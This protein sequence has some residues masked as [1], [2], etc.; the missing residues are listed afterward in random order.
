MR[1][2]SFTSTTAAP[3]NQ[4]RRCHNLGTLS[5]I[6]WMRRSSQRH[7]CISSAC[8]ASPCTHH[9]TISVNDE[10]EDSLVDPW[11]HSTTGVTADV[12][13]PADIFA[14]PKSTYSPSHAVS[15]STPLN[16]PSRHPRFV[17]TPGGSPSARHQSFPSA[18]QPA[19]F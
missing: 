2:H 1:I 16:D 6:R 18:S 15:S 7:T 3:Y 4:L 14:L 9:Y 8:N 19:C 11:L 13:Q 10:C 5:L 17:H 12:S